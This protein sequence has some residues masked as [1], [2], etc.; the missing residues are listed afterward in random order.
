MTCFG[1]ESVN[2]DPGVSECQDASQ[3]PRHPQGLWEIVQMT[4]ATP[5]SAHLHS[6]VLHFFLSISAFSLLIAGEHC[7]LLSPGSVHKALL[8]TI[9][10]EDF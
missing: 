4:C 3:S 10:G 9:R 6:S 8:I 7:W 1:L 5:L 2:F